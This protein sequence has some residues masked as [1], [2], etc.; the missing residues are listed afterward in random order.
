M[1]ANASGKT[2]GCLSGG[3]QIFGGSMRSTNF[4]WIGSLFCFGLGSGSM[5]WTGFPSGP[6]FAHSMR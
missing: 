3:I 2:L 1:T 5:A 4:T 6:S